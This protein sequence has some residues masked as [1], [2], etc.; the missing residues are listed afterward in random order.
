MQYRLRNNYSKNPEMA[1][2]EILIDRG[3]QEIETFLEP[4]NKCELNPYDLDNIEAAADKL[5]NHLRKNSSVC[6]IVDADCDGFT[7]SAILWNYIKE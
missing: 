5:L 3:V 1:L 7:S 4:S 2:K 6:L